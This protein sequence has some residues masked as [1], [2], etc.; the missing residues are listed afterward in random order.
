MKKK[1]H[2]RAKQTA[3]TPTGTS[4]RPAG[5]G[6][7]YWLVASALVFLLAGVALWWTQRPA[8]LTPPVPHVE[9]QP[10]AAAPTYVGREVCVECHAGQN[11][12]WQ[13]SQHD[14]AMQKAD[15]ATVLGDFGDTD[16][17]YNGI[18][19]RF[20]RQ[21]GRFMVRTDGP[22]GS[23]H[24][25]PISYTFG[26]SPLQQ[27]LVEF[28]GG[29][30][31]ALSIAWDSRPEKNGGQRWFHLYPDEQVTY[32]DVLHWTKPG[33]NWNSQCA[34]CHSTHLQKNYNPQNR[35]FDTHWS[36]LDVSCEAC[37]GPASNHI[38][39]ARKTPG[40]EKFDTAKGLGVDL[41]ERAGAQWSIN[42]NTGNAVRS[43]PR[44]QDTEIEVCAPCHSRRSA[45]SDDYVPGSP[46]LDYYRPALL[47]G[48]LYFADGQVRDEV[49]VYG[50]FLQSRMYHAG[51]TCSDCHEPHSLQLRQPGN[52]V[53]LQCHA[54]G[55][56]DSAAHH[57][58]N[59]GGQGSSCAACHMPTRNYMVID[60]R[61]D[62]SIR[63]PRPDLSV[64][65]GVPNA[66]NNCHAEKTPE[67]ADA[68]VKDWYGHVPAGYQRYAKALA[69]ARAGDPSA[70]G[71]MAGLIRDPA[72][73]DIARATLL[74]EMGPYLG[75]ETLDVLSSGLWHDNPLVRS[76]TVRLLE[77]APP[78]LRVQLAFPMLQDGLRA[79]RIE[80]ARVLAGM[81]PGDLDNNQQVMLDKG[82]REYIQ[83]QEV[84]AERPEAQVNLGN[85]YASQAQTDKAVSAYQ[86]ARALNPAFI[87]AYVNLADL[88]RSMD[89]DAQGEKV[90]RQA[91]QVVP[92]SAEAHYALGLLLVRQKQADKA[93]DELKLAAAANTEEPRYAY[94][95]GVALYSTGHP[96]QAISVLT[97]AQNRYPKNTDILN[98]LI[99]FHREQGD[100]Q[101]ADTYTRKR[102]ALLPPEKGR[103]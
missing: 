14:L 54:A 72:T 32:K 27:Y 65:L 62:H 13:G 93:L 3:P 98:A 25:Y 40:W 21:D 43:R 77:Q 102:E 79:V 92:D 15:A 22:D 95:W 80:A 84:N 34:A 83:A 78:K 87:P 68:Q 41:G 36:E 55:K 51:V 10:A 52:G 56:Y 76:A 100:Q 18:T 5:V 73:P 48:D 96:Q 26:V 85:L 101:A 37:H 8:G 16:F 4:S 30:L 63:I 103:Q 75:P 59:P 46:L 64:T 88:Y 53:C 94:T 33:Q 12:L 66:C 81:P 6:R 19:S 50:S 99:S 61:R 57:F 31:Q 2:A 38:A 82:L 60:A 70:G 91:L 69:A 89:K 58:H 17:V 7:L 90:L 29:R 28:P 42:A 1:P 86:T 20:Y 67:W 35:T 97:A 24:D 71:E 9:R 11:R 45:I 44:A 47:T 23:L 39:W 49:Y 74:A